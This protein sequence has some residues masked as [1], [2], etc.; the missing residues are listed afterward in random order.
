MPGEE[1]ESRRSHALFQEYEAIWDSARAG[2]EKSREWLRRVGATPPPVGPTPE[3]LGERDAQE[4]LDEF[5]DEVSGL[6]ER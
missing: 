5:W 6:T 3:E 2:N 4:F 1:A